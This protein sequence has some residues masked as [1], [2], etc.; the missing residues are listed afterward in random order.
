MDINILDGIWN[1][2]LCPKKDVIL[3]CMLSFTKVSVIIHEMGTENMTAFFSMSFVAYNPRPAFVVVDIETFEQLP[4]FDVIHWNNDGYI[5]LPVVLL[6]Y[7][8]QSRNL[9]KWVWV[10]IYCWRREFYIHI[11]IFTGLVAPDLLHRTCFRLNLHRA[12]LKVEQ[13]MFLIKTINEMCAVPCWQLFCFQTYV[14]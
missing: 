13:A 6:E 2:F 14:A 5:F 12:C 1:P 9:K 8:I 10:W 7:C 3:P 11:E 4:P